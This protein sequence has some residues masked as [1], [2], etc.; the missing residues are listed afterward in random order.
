[1]TNSQLD[2]F[3]AYSSYKP[4]SVNSIKFIDLFAGIGGF[5][6]AFEAAKYECV[7]SSEINEHCQKV[8]KDNFK[9]D[10]F[11]DVAEIDA[12][13]LPNFQMLLAGFPCQPFSICGKKKGFEDTRGTLFF[14]ICRIID[15]KRPNVVVLEN[16]KHLIH[17]DSGNTLSTILSTLE[18]LKY[19]VSYKL[20]NSKD[21]GVPQNRERIVIIA[22]KDG[23]KFNFSK[24]KTQPMVQLKDFLDKDGEFE[25]LDPSEYTILDNYTVQKTGLIFIGY[26]NKNIWKTGI[27]P[28][29]EHLSRVHRQPNRIYSVEGTHPTLPSQE[30]SGRFFI[31]LPDENK[32][33]KLTINECY[34]I[35]GFPDNFQRANVLSE[36]Y[37]Q[38]GNSVCVP[39]MKEIALQLK[40]QGLING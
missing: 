31:Y 26:R 7:F 22:H 14:D 13:E 32:V 30:S 4:S 17:H 11:S 9:E 23:L 21:F 3:N 25:Y 39:M 27:R 28:N 10:P 1:M 35:M 2:I 19:T 38:I 12:E 8:Y 36:Q 6:I 20:L 5:R 33:R 18:S 24:L 40:E 29:T 34:R 16:V 37:K 15:I